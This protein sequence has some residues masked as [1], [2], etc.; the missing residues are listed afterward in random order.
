MSDLISKLL[1][2]NPKKRLGGGGRDALEI[3]SH[4]FFNV[5][6]FLVSVTMQ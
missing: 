5:S 6:P 1:E 3:K 4:P 2:N